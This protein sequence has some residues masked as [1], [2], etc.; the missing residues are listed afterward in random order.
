MPAEIGTERFKLPV[1]SLYEDP[2]GALWVGSGNLFRL[3]DGKWDCWGPRI[4]PG[5]NNVL[6]NASVLSVLQ[7]AAGDVWV[8]TKGGVAASTASEASVLRSPMVFP[9]T[10]PGQPGPILTGRFGSARPK[11]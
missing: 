1:Q 2:G 5:Q 3:K 8:G 9:P 6:P 7:D 4:A 10:S 11:E